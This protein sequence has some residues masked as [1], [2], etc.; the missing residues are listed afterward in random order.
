M[1]SASRSIVAV[2]LLVVALARNSLTTMGKPKGLRKPPGAISSSSS[3]TL[4]YALAAVVALALLGLF[5]AST[6]SDTT[7]PA[8]TPSPGRAPHTSSPSPAT[9]SHLLA[10]ELA[11]AAEA[12]AQN[13][14]CGDRHEM[15]EPWHKLGACRRAVKWQGASVGPP[16]MAQLCKRT[17][18]FCAGAA[19]RAPLVRPEAKCQRDNT[20]AAVPQYELNALFENIMTNPEYEKYT[21][22]AL[23]KDPWLLQLHDFLSEDEAEAFIR[24]CDRMD[25]SLAGDELSPVRTSFQCWCNYGNCFA[26]PL[27]HR[28]VRRINNLTG[29]AYNNGEDLQARA[30]AILRRATLRRAI[31]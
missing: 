8:P 15:C 28:V 31:C 1:R 21:P 12:E 29:T 30:R 23:S 2:V 27:V 10:A 18:G 5:V 20:T 17:C 19:G 9:P 25:R 11:A 24:A 3:P 26:D 7:A 6:L 4:T 13:Q 16:Q 22:A 14:P